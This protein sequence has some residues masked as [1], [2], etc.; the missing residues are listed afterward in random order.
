[1]FLTLWLGV[2]NKT[3]GKLTFSN[4]GHNPPLIKDNNGFRYLNINAGIVLGV[5]EDFDYIKVGP[6]IKHLGPLKS[7]TTNQRLY[8]RTLDGDFEDITY[9]FWRQQDIAV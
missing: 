3:T 9:R 7:A 2:Y 8:R 4:A 1:M 6:Y 5:M